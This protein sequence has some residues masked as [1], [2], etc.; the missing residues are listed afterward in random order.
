MGVFRRKSIKLTSEEKA[1]IA[2]IIDSQV[3]IIARI[4]PLVNTQR[5]TLSISLVFFQ[6]QSKHW[7]NI[8]L[9]EKLKVGYVRL[10]SDGRSEYVIKN[11]SNVEK[12][13][14]IF[15]SSFRMRLELFR[16]I[17]MLIE[18]Q[19]IT[20]PSESDIIPLGHFDKLK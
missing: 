17:L 4:V 2:G 11:R 3:Y 12:I 5:T 1:Y 9:H 15:Y 10:R 16:L 20:P 13:L 6:Q 7:F 8:W 14:R 18:V 19:K